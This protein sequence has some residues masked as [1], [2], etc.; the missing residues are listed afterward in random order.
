MSRLAIS[1]TSLNRMPFVAPDPDA[2]TIL[3]AGQAAPVFL[4]V[5]RP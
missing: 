2:E 1:K 4:L 3:F 5:D